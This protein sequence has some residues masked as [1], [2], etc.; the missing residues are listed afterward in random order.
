MNWKENYQAK[1]LSVKEVAKKIVS[2]DRINV[3]SCTS[4]P[5]ELFEAIADRV[6]ELENVTINSGS[7]LYPFKVLQSPEF[8]GKIN[9]YTNFYS[10]FERAFFSSGNVNVN[11]VNL[12]QIF[13]AQ[14]DF[15]KPNIL[16]CDVSQPDEEG[17]MYYG[18]V[19]TIANGEVAEIV[20][21]VIVQVNKYQ[22]RVPGTKNKIHVNDV[23][24]I[25]EHD[26]PMPVF[27]NPE[28]TE[29]DQKIAELLIPEIPDGA[30]LQLGI[31][32]LANAIGY[33][34]TKKKNLSIYSEMFT[35]SLVY[36]Y[37]Q[38]VIT[39]E[40]RVAFGMGNQ[41]L[42]DFVDQGPVQF[43]PI[44]EIN[45]PINISKV[46]NLVG[47]NACLMADLT[48]QICSE[49]IGHYQYSSTGG[50]LDFVNGAMLSKSAKT[51]LCLPATNKKKDGTVTS[52]I[53]LNLPAGAIVT[54]P[55]TQVQ[56]VVT[57]YGIAD[58]KNKPIR[59]R[60]EEMIKIAHPDFR[61]SLRQEAI[62]AG[63]LVK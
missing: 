3:G 26:A 39:G 53:T 6:D 11:S 20:D 23:T 24:W 30:T 18:P 46:K 38:G 49:S 10:A 4:A 22:P 8:V 37:K 36:L 12:S 29:V 62:A 57:E 9:F 2:G 35:D 47:I 59:A 25:C 16:I 14:K 34:L 31:G 19:G 58:L 43:A 45:N 61:D 42:Y 63:L 40:M 5:I 32:G 21:K 44:S 1:L 54:V 55:R 17:Y 27:P 48:G 56:Y 15:Y 52:C 13:E 28:V 7:S 51:F 60:V 50:Q 41:E 33:G